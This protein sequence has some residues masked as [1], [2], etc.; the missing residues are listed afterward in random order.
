MNWKLVVVRYNDSMGRNG[1]AGQS[2]VEILIA[3]GVS[4]LLIGSVVTTYIVSLRSNA[5][6][7]ISAVATQLA[8]ET[9]D[10]IKAISEA[11]WNA[12][13][14]GTKNSDYYLALSDNVFVV[15]SGVQ[16]VNVNTDVYTRSFRVQNIER[17]PSGEI[18]AAGL[19]VDD[20]ST[21]LVTVTVG[22]TVAG[23]SGETKV[24]GYISR[25]KN[26]SLR[27]SSWSEGATGEGPFIGQTS[28]FSSSTNVD[29][30]SLPG[31]IKVLNF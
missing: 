19:G 24:G 15:T 14:S 9:F 11:N 30:S 3:V 31:V 16:S 6:A 23:S 13:Y 4:S 1:I 20:P 28:S 27:S 29:W 18:V 26:A 17:N 22:W 25:V 2:L 12:I 8:Q 7:R 21:Q 5:T 10:N